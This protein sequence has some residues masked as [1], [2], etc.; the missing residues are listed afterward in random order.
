MFDTVTIVSPLLAGSL[1]R[2]DQ[3]PFEGRSYACMKMVQCMVVSSPCIRPATIHALPGK[4][5]YPVKDSL[6]KLLRRRAVR[7]QIKSKK[8]AKAAAIHDAVD[9]L[10]D[11]PGQ[12]STLLHFP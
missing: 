12:V 3:R 9:D 10:T 7:L 4:S 2:D 5:C 8:G 6:Q 11:G 1:S